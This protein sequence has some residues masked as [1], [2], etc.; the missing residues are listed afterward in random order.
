[1]PPEFRV[2]GIND[3][4]W[5]DGYERVLAAHRAGSIPNIDAIFPVVELRLDDFIGTDSRLSRLNVHAIFAPGTEPETIRAQFLSRL[6]KS[7]TLT[8]TYQPLQTKWQ[9]IPTRDALTELGRL[10][11]ESVPQDEL[12]NFGSDIS[13]GFNNW[14]IPLIA[15]KEAIEGSPFP[16]RPLIGLGKTEWE[17]IPWNENTIASKKSLVSES[18]LLFTAAETP[19]ACE[20]SVQRLH[21]AEVNYRLL[22]CSD[23]HHFSDS[24]EKDRIGNC[25]T[26]VCADATL[27]GL[28]H[29][30]FEYRSRI[31]IGERPP[32]LIRQAADPTNFITNVRIS[33]VNPSESPAPVL[34][35]EIPLNSGFVAVIGNKGSGKSALLDSIALAANSHSEE[36][37][38][39]LSDRRFR[40][41]RNNK[42]PYYQVE[43]STADGAATSPVSLGSFADLDSPERVRYL[44]QSLLEALCNKEPGAPDD[45]F[46]AE[47]RSIIFSHI[48]E[49]ERLASRSLEEL[50]DKR[51]RGLDQEI[52]FNRAEMSKTNA[53]I[54]ELEERSRSS[55]LKALKANLAAIKEQIKSHDSA[56]PPD[57]VEPHAESAVSTQQLAGMNTARAALIDS[58]Q[59]ERELKDAYASARSRLNSA[60]N[61]VRVIDVFAATSREFFDRAQTL[62]EECGLEV[63]ELV[64]VSI[65]KTA[66]KDRVTELT[67]EVTRLA[68][69]LEPNGDL[70]SARADSQRQ[71]EEFEAVLDRPRREFEH[72]RH[73]LE[74]WTEAR[75]QLVGNETREGTQE[76]FKGQIAEAEG[77]PTTLA[78]LREARLQ[79]AK[80]IHDLLLEK[81]G[82]FREL[83]AP[84][85]HFMVESPLNNQVSLEFQANLEIGEFVDRFLSDIDR[86]VSGSFFGVPTSEQRVRKRIRA[87]QPSSWESVAEFLSEQDQD[88]H[89]DRRDMGKPV[90]VDSPSDLLRKGRRL[91]DVYDHLYGLEYLDAEYELRSDGRAIT[92]LSPGQKGT[93]LLI[94][95]LLIDQSGRPIALDQPDENL[96]NHTVHTLLRPAIR[97]AK[98]NRQVIVVTHSPNLAVVG[99]TDQVIV[100]ESDGK[101]FRYRSGS[102]ENPVVRDLVVRVLEGTW[103]AFT[104]RARKYSAS[105][106]DEA[107][108]ELAD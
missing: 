44:P 96:D 105:E 62:A 60:H 78:E 70:Y 11:K 9:A 92:E 91:T 100:A 72:Q 88:L 106:F 98:A 52:A 49:H 61:L 56:R 28:K 97:A 3:Y 71:L 55:R 22:D 47:L 75:S 108:A 40:N 36:H 10:I 38:T 34:D 54:A 4:L 19:T 57:P 94:F 101:E 20:R 8:S 43:V 37:F 35:V 2:L 103:P 80:R 31:F 79:S 26:W 5:V 41:P 73:Q 58:H 42:A 59:K 95:Y 48:P 15:V 45:A 23:A 63:D 69:L 84:V 30:L 1:L 104:D 18:D 6:V 81:V 33:P 68:E 12:T 82:M 50:L 76:Y 93:I 89:A 14:V 102:I 25:F 39:F 66:L 83:Y 16:E 67:D 53:T 85:E 21:Q 107:Q 32:L 87:L 46:E 24:A 7:F 74:A 13:E 17:S 65:D 51:G 29:A 99:D 64:K 77:I 86:G 27:A 90:P